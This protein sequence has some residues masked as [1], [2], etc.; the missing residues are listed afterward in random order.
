MKFPTNSIT[1]SISLVVSSVGIGYAQEIEK[2]EFTKE[3]KETASS[4]SLFG[5]AFSQ[6]MQKAEEGIQLTSYSMK[7]SQSDRQ[8]MKEM[9][10]NVQVVKK[11]SSSKKAQQISRNVLPLDRLKK[12]RSRGSRRDF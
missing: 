8:R 10:K 11:G 9:R 7:K 2:A 3:K 5:K 12:K 1:L 4:T 6:L